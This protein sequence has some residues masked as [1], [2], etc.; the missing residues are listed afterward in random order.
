MADPQPGA[1]EPT[2]TIPTTLPY[3]ST[4]C[5]RCRVSTPKWCKVGWMTEL[6][7]NEGD[8]AFLPLLHTWFGAHSSSG[9]AR[10]G[11]P[12]SRNPRY[13]FPRWIGTPT[14][15]QYPGHLCG[16]AGRSGAGTSTLLTHDKG[17]SAARWE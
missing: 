14:W 16:G 4:S 8:M 9:R 7:S 10:I 13:R 6:G 2:V 1:V 17:R 12:S 5:S 15:P 11:S 3:Q